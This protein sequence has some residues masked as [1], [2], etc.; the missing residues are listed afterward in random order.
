M[1]AGDRVT[2]YRD[3]LTRQEPEGEATLIRLVDHCRGFHEGDRLESWR[4]QLDGGRRCV[5]RV[6]L[7]QGEG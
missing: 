7:V 2:I 3:P 5:E 6:I 4:V 1:K